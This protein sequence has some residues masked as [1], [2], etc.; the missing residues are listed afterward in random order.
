MYFGFE[1]FSSHPYIMMMI[2]TILCNCQLRLDLKC[3]WYLRPTVLNSILSEDTPKVGMICM[4]THF[5]TTA[6]A[7]ATQRLHRDSW[8]VWKESRSWKVDSVPSSQKK[9]RCE[10]VCVLVPVSFW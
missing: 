5:I 6:P 2:E 3:N 7:Y 10:W 4:E 8:V 9:I 1:T